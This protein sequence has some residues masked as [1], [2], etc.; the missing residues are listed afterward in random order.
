MERKKTTKSPESAQDSAS[1]PC[2]G[3]DL[4]CQNIEWEMWTC[5]G[6]GLDAVEYAVTIEFQEGHDQNREADVLW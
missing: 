5:P 2:C 1:C 4:P 6:C 3:A